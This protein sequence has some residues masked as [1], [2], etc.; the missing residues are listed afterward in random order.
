MERARAITKRTIKAH[1]AVKPLDVCIKWSGGYIWFD[2]R[3]PRDLS[4]QDMLEICRSSKC[5]S[6]R[7]M[8]TLETLAGPDYV[9]PRAVDKDR[10][11]AAQARKI[12]ELEAKIA[13][14]ESSN[15]WRR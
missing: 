12:V 6:E 13:R 3:L 7:D 11:I 14:L 2:R 1:R 15:A 9:S 10:I 5:A 8:E 4:V